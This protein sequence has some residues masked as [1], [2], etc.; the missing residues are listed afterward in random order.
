MRE[1]IV[2]VML[3]LFYIGKALR[4]SISLS[5]E[6]LIVFNI[7]FMLMALVTKL[8]SQLFEEEKKQ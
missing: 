7:I 3:K 2:S 1:S 4:S 6:I 5:N 8:N